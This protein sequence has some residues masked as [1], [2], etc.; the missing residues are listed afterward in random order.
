MIFPINLKLGSRVYHLGCERIEK[1]KEIEKFR[2]YARNSPYKYIILQNNRPLVRT[3]LNLK[4]KRYSWKVIEGNINN[5][6]ALDKTIE[7]IEWYLEMNP[8]L[9]TLVR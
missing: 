3:K 5:K 4:T 2:V 6:V 7:I 8:D 1:G 9:P